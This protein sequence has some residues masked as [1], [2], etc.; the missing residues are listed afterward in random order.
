MKT[1]IIALAIVLSTGLACGDDGDGGDAADG[2]V[3]DA[4][5]IDASVDAMV[6]ADVP[7]PDANIYPASLRDTGLYSD[8]DGR[9]IASDVFEYEVAYPLWSDGAEKR[10]W[11]HLPAGTQIDTTDMDF[12]VYP[13]GTKLWTEFS[14][15]GTLLEARFLQKMGPTP[16]DW[17]WISYGWNMAQTE[18][19]EMPDGADDVLGTT[20]DIPDQRNCSKCHERT[21]DIALGFS[22][23]QLAHAQPGVNLASLVTD[24]LVTIDPPGVSPYFVVPGVGDELAVLGYFHGNCGGCH[25][26]NSEVMD[27]TNLNLRLEVATLGTVEE[28]TS[29]STIVGIPQQLGPS[30]PT[31]LIEE[32]DPDASMIFFRMGLRDGANQMPPRGTEVVDTDFM[33]I[34]SAWITSLTP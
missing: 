3:Q 6:D 34:L 7:L 16:A 27:T 24:S 13:E 22:A 14:D 29:Y 12:W 10:R 26:K 25:N 1:S 31:A 32:G 33:V 5:P 23:I 18:A 15:N 4:A 28:T 30:G 20:F 21:P 8:F 11:V 2:G 9:I 19:L 17:I